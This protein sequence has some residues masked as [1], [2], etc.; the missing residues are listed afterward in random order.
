MNLQNYS[1]SVKVFNRLSGL[2][3][4]TFAMLFSQKIN[5]QEVQVDGAVVISVPSG[6]FMGTGG[7]I[8][9][10]GTAAIDNKGTVE[11]K[12]NWNN[13]ANGLINGS[14]GT[15]ILDGAAQSVTGTSPT[16][17]NNLTISGTGTKTLTLA[18]TVT[19]T[20]ALNDRELATGANTLT[21]SATGL[22]TRTTGFISSLPNGFLA[23]NTNSTS[24]YSFPVGNPGGSFFR[25]LEVTPATSSSN[26][27]KVRLVGGSPS[28]DG[29]STT[30]TDGSICSANSTFYHRVTQNSA[31]AAILTMYFSSGLDG[32][33]SRIAHWQGA[34]V[35]TNMNPVTIVAGAYGL[36]NGLSSTSWSNFSTEAFAL[37]YAP[38]PNTPTA[39][40]ATS[41]GCT[42]FTANWSA[43]T[44]ANHFSSDITNYLIDVATDPGFSNILPAY[45]NFD[46]GTSTSLNISTGVTTGTNYYYRVRAKDACGTS[47]SSSVIGPI[48]TQTSS[49][50]PTASSANINPICPSQ[51]VTLTASGGS[52]GAG[53]V[54]NWY[55]GSCGGPSVGT[56]NPLSIS[57]P[58]STTTYFALYQGTCN[59][60]TCT[61][62]TLNINSPSTDPSGITPSL[63]PKCP[64]V[65][66]TLTVNG[67]SLGT[68]A[69]WVWYAGG[70][71]GSPIGTGTTISVNPSSATTYF[72]RAEGICNV[73]NCASVNITIGSPSTDPSSVSGGTSIF[74]CSG[75]NVTLTVQGGSLGT[76]ATWKWYLNGCGGTSIGS[77]SSITVSPSSTSTYFVR[78]EG[79]CNTTNCASTT[80]NVNAPGAAGNGFWNVYC[81]ASGDAAGNNNAWGASFYKGLYT[82]NA[83]NF[84]TATRWG[85]SSTPSNANATGGNAY[86][87]CAIGVD[88][89]SYRYIR[90]GFTPG[91]YYVTGIWDDY[92]NLLIDGTPVATGTCCAN[93]LTS[94]WTGNITSS[95]IVEMR[96]S[97]GGGG[98]AGGGSFCL[99]PVPASEY[100]TYPTW[101]AYVY[102]NQSTA[103][104]DY[105]GYYNPSSPGGST[106]L[107]ENYGTN[108]P[109]GATCKTMNNDQFT[110]RYKSNIN[111]AKGIYTF[112]GSNDDGRR[113]SLDGGTNYVF[114]AFTATSGSST[115]A[116]LALSGTYPV[117]YD[118]YENSGGAS[119]NLSYSCANANAGTLTL[120]QSCNS[121]TATITLNGATGYY[122]LQ[123]SPDGNTWTNIDVEGNTVSNSTP[124]F[125]V[126]SSSTLQY[127]VVV[128][129]CNGSVTSNSV[130]VI[131][132][133]TTGNMVISSNVTLGGTLNIS[134]DFIL[135]NGATITVNKGCPLVIN[136]T[137]I[138]IN[139]TINGNGAGYSGGSGG[140]G[141]NAYAN[142]GNEDDQQS[143]GGKGFAGN[144][145]G[146]PGAGA[147]GSDGGDANGRARDCNSLGISNDDGHFGGGGGA[148][149]GGGGA[150]GSNGGF[151][152]FGAYGGSFNNGNN[153][154]QATFGP[155]GPG[156]SSNGSSAGVSDID[157]GSGGSGAGGGGGGKNSGQSGSSGGDGGGSISLIASSNLSVSGTITANGT[158]GGKG[159]DGST[160]SDNVYGCT[161]GNC[162]SCTVFSGSTY[163]ADAG[164]GGGGGGGSGGGIKLQA[165]GN[166][167]ITGSLSAAGGGGGNAGRPYTSDAN[168]DDWANGG[169]GGSGGRIKI[170][171]NPC[172]ANNITPSVSTNG[173]SGGLAGNGGSGSSASA[174]TYVNNITHPAFVPLTASVTTDPDQT[175]CFGDNTANITSS[176][177]ASGGLGI[178]SYQWYKSTTTSVGTTGSG[179]SPASGWNTV[180]GATSA[181]LSTAVIGILPVTT[182]FQ[183]RLSSGTCNTWS[184]VTKITVDE[185]APVINCPASVSTVSDP[186]SC[187]AVVN[188]IAPVGT[189]NCPGASTVLQSGKASGSVFLPGITTNTLELRIR[190]ELPQHVV[191]L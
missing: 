62:F 93:S 26:T 18:A 66:I 177:A 174:G 182:Y 53:A 99:L 36:T 17:F 43:S 138:T 125:T 67:G 120:N 104:S 143:T 79:T 76:G 39:S 111:F 106:L 73:T 150:Y 27:Y 9:L 38:T 60:T 34:P 70:C 6:T 160:G 47:G 151:G 191:S 57:S 95:S 19:G 49:T 83:T 92:V 28:A 176:P 16:T 91:I 166:T 50:P 71:G 81:Y 68:G 94:L 97:E 171:L 13:N 5:A 170:I 69:N 52:M 168:C 4:M 109:A 141:G 14:A 123:S 144:A 30:S 21:I 113:L 189:D 82:D 75:T 90:T 101:N 51:P 23:R 58:S 108:Q 173:G 84:S 146:G 181:T 152:A 15:V 124:T 159:G 41:I 122:Q 100:G 178:Y 185:T 59:T 128:S 105:I 8:T 54:V 140:S 119:A 161:K 31:Q 85:S 135:N 121:S 56:G 133:S 37:A 115:S 169:G 63:N 163:V 156:G 186:S 137:N 2:L 11:L 155:A 40:A 145:G 77:G 22:I 110:V 7:S 190:K 35:W 20:L 188:Y 42:S 107:N 148:G 165:F 167:V 130:S 187:G 3:V 172:G 134:G 24:V 88:N 129:S 153:T 78:A 179:T 118:L 158:S 80:I 98:S 131:G 164:G 142:C 180:S 1:K 44:D 117:V 72:V 32:N 45:N 29:F 175:L 154:S 147:G 12:G 116:S 127:R 126:S 103:T 55:S 89:H 157:M 33:L 114:D 46:A 74:A 61:S 65:P 112:T 64:G 136:A 48:S 132:S 10:N 96:F 149:S 87:G 183:L 139:G 86:S 102:D 25:P 162:G 184:D